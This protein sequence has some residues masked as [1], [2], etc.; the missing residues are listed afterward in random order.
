M[1]K[2]FKKTLT[3]IENP[4]YD[5]LESLREYYPF[6][7]GR[8]SFKVRD[9]T[10]CK[11]QERFHPATANIGW[12]DGTTCKTLVLLSTEI[13]TQEN[14][15]REWLDKMAYALGGIDRWPGYEPFP[16]FDH[17]PLNDAYAKLK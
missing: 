9:R 2:K 13:F 6:G 1:P 5:K 15:R 16:H 14:F 12:G 17:R 10:K 7:R 11:I 8:P 3:K 4:M